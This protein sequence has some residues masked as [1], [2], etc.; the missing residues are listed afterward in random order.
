[1]TDS[2]RYYCAQWNYAALQWVRKEDLPSK[3]Y[4]WKRM[5]RFARMLNQEF[6]HD[7]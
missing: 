5:K 1:M 3:F 4:W 2:Q 7:H 6:N